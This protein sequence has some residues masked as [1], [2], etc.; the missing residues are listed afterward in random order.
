[1]DI[2]Q[3]HLEDYLKRRQ[4]Y[5]SNL[6]GSYN[7]NQTEIYKNLFALAVVGFG[8][9]LAYIDQLTS[10]VAYALW[11]LTAFGLG[12]SVGCCFLFSAPRRRSRIF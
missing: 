8:Y 9:N 4:D 6:Q 10:K 2:K 1:M 12:V 7:L 3:L 11:L 5:I